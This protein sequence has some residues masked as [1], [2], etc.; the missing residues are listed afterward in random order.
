MICFNCL[1]CILPSELAVIEFKDR[2][3]GTLVKKGIC[4]DCGYKCAL[5]LLDL[6]RKSQEKTLDRI[7]IYNSDNE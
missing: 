6:E 1:K 4:N 5:Y 3:G 7:L 2:D